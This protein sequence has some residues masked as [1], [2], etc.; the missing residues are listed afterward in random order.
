MPKKYFKNSSLTYINILIFVYLHIYFLNSLLNRYISPVSK[1]CIKKNV[2]RL[3]NLRLQRLPI[4]SRTCIHNN[5]R[6]G[7]IFC[8]FDAFCVF[9]EES[10]LRFFCALPSS[11]SSSCLRFFCA[12]PSSSSS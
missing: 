7:S 11:S 4:K 6:I 3:I 8:Y 2:F 1:L 5:S 12:L 10:S 9:D